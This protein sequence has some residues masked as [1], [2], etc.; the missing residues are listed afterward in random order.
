MLQRLLHLQP[1]A[2]D[3]AQIAAKHA[4]LCIRCNEGAG[5]VHLLLIHQHTASQDECL[6]ALARGSQPLLNQQLV[7]PQLHRA[8]NPSACLQTHWQTIP[9][10]AIFDPANLWRA[11][12]ALCRRIAITCGPGISS[13]PSSVRGALSRIPCNPEMWQVRRYE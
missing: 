13:A 7:Q 10:G 5:F 3:V 12:R 8:R 1:A 9:V 2:A 4:Q 6:G 11:A